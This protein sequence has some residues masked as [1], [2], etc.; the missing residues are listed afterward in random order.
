MAAAV[1]AVTVGLLVAC[2]GATTGSSSSPG[3][4]PPTASAQPPTPVVELPPC[5]RLPQVDARADGLPALTLPCL[6][7]GPDVRLSD[8]RDKPTVLNV[9]A[10][11]CTNCDREMRLLARLHEAAGDRVRVLGLHYKAS[12]SFGL[13]SAGDFGVTFASVH[14]EDGDRT[15]AE[16]GV[17]GP[18]TTLFVSSDGRV[19]GRKTGEI[20]SF[21]ELAA[22]VENHL[23]VVV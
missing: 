13:R 14:D 3:K 22:L 2:S 16:L 15:T 4:S 9:W 11:W 1:L 17:L 18:P 7:S 20:R 23:G 6:S 21:E 12:R 10:A 8:L 5:P 19:V